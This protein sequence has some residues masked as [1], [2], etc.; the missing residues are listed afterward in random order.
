[1]PTTAAG[2]FLLTAKDIRGGQI[3]Y[4]SAR[5]TSME[6]FGNKLTDKSRPRIG[7][8]LLTKDGSIGRVAVCDR[9]N[10]CINQSVAL[11]RPNSRI[12]PAFLS[13]LLQ[14]PAYQERME[15][16][17]DGSTIKHIYITRVD[18]MPVSV[19]G[20]CEQ[21][22]VIE[23]L[24]ALD[25]KIAANTKLAETADRLSQ[26]VFKSIA[27][28]GTSVP[29]STTARFVNGKAFTKGASGTGRVVIRIAEL[30]SGLG[31]STVFSDAEVGDDFLARPGDI[32]FAWSGSL[33]L[34]RWFR[35]EAIVNQ[36]IFKVIPS[37]YPSWLVYELLRDRLAYFKGIAADKAT[38]M[39]HIQRGHL[40]GL[41][42]LPSSHSISGVDEL[43]TSL[44][45][46][47]LLAERENETLA[48]TRDTLL[49]QLMSGTLRVRDAET[50]LEEA[51]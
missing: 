21:Q 29:L 49:P 47:R 45:D 40:D 31:G 16:D 22:A 28:E 12:I 14:T 25:D 13:Y 17:S 23:V 46:R 8:V 51:V 4:E 48:A 43:M 38:T 41:V 44:W 2:P 7:D 9:E 36:H 27:R 1:M 37:G 24:G 34:H 19:P 5:H 18:K 32:L 39:G 26:A 15:R 10:V 33:T 35:P 11:L 42:N 20:L 6:A 30:N 50:H 3:D